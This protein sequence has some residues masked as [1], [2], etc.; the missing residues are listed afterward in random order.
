M[1]TRPSCAIPVLLA[2]AAFGHAVG[3]QVVLETG[4]LQLTITDGGMLESLSA[5]PSG[6]EYSAVYDRAD[7]YGDR[8]AGPIAVAYRGNRAFPASQVLHSGDRLTVHFSG[9]DVAA[10]YQVRETK[11]YLAFELISLAGAPVDRID[12]PQLRVRK[13]SR[14]GR[15][16]ETYLLVW[17]VGDAVPLRLPMLPDRLEAMRPFGKPQPVEAEGAGSIIRIVGRTYLRQSGITP[18]EARSLFQQAR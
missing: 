4:N 9:T 7:I 2:L 13:L 6:V 12:P 5:K 3:G 14:V 1:K 10:T 11:H 17:A 18:D 16:N 8:A 15:S